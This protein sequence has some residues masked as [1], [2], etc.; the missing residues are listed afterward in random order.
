V[1]AEK[2]Y[3][4]L[5]PMPEEAVAGRSL[6]IGGQLNLQLWV[7]GQPVLHSD[8]CPTLHLPHRSLVTMKSVSGKDE[9]TEHRSFGA[10]RLPC[11]TH[12]EN[13]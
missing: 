11:V 7:P 1:E 5:I 13:T 12:I 9:E 8:P 10:I 4:P 2:R 3:M 6:C